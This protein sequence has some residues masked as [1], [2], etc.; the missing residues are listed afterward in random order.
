VTDTH[1]LST[2]SRVPSV[3]I[4][5]INRGKTPAILR[6]VS[7]SLRHNPKFPLVSTEA[8]EEESYEVIAPGDQ[9][10]SPPFGDGFRYIEL[11][12]A[13]DAPRLRRGGAA[14]LLIL[15][16]LLT[17]SDPMDA[18][19]IDS[20]CMRAAPNLRSFRI[21]ESLEPYNRH[22]TTYPQKNKGD[23]GEA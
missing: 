12:D 8:I 17:Y 1:T 6:S 2:Y 20:F 9:V 18:M 14:E 7:I 22:K 3:G 5:I 11:M 10:R 23:G 15:H 19:H 16:G 4:R 13:K 21:D